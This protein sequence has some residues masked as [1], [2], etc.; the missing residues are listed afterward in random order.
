M[1]ATKV[2]LTEA[3]TCPENDPLVLTLLRALETYWPDV[4]VSHEKSDNG[5]TCLVYWSDGSGVY[6]SFALNVLRHPEMPLWCAVVDDSTDPL[7]WGATCGDVLDKLH[8]WALLSGAAMI[9]GG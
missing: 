8:K 1:H 5:E 9:D 4:A 2:S 3:E 7:V 6:R